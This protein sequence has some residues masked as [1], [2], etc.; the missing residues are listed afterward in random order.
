[1][2]SLPGLYY[3]LSYSCSHNLP[4]PQDI[5]ARVAPNDSS[6]GGV[7]TVKSSRSYFSTTATENGWKVSTKSQLSNHFPLLQWKNFGFS[8]IPVESTHQVLL[9]N[10]LVGLWHSRVL[11]SSSFSVFVETQGKKQ[12]FFH[13]TSGKLVTSRFHLQRAHIVQI[14]PNFCFVPNARVRRAPARVARRVAIFA[15]MSRY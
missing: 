14:S 6:F 2:R 10:N 5:F 4:Q 13:C 7:S 12:R 1:M 11:S 9:L 15:G 8:T 3:V